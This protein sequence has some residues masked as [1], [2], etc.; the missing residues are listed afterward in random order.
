MPKTV[1]SFLI[2]ACLFPL[3]LAL[4]RLMIAWGPKLGLVDEPDARRIHT[5]PIPRAGGV[6]LFVTMVTGLLLLKWLGEGFTGMLSGPWLLHFLGASTLLAVIGIVD[7]RRGV[8]AWVKLVVQV[9]A[10][11][12]MFLHNPGGAGI[13][14]GFHVPWIID[15]G[16]HV[17]WTVALINAFNLID[18][19]DGL[20]SG[21][22]TI[23]LVILAALAAVGHYASNGF[24]IMVMAVGLMGFLRYNFHPARIFLGDT[25]SM[26]VGFF[27]ASVGTVTVGRHAVVAGLLLPLLVGGVPLLDVGLAVWRRGMRRLADSRPGKATIHIF[28]ADRDHLHHRLLNW[29]LSQRQAVFAIYGLAAVTSMLALLPIL[30]GTNLVTVSV[31]GILVISLVGLRYI[32][33]VEFLE[34]GRGLRAY[35]R[36]PRNCR[37]AMVTYLIH[38]LIALFASAMLASWLVEKGSARAYDWKEAMPDVMIFSVCTLVGL[39]LG[40]AHARRWARAS[41]HDFAECILWMVCGAGISFAFLGMADSDFSFHD[42]IFH[43]S[44]LALGT[45]AVFASRCTGFLLQESV[46]D[47]MHRKR[48]MRSKRSS[49]T[50]IIYGAGDLGELFLCHLRLSQPEVWKD[51]HFVGFIDDSEGLR[52]RRMRGFPILGSL[53]Q[54]PRLVAQN[55]VNCIMVTSSVL[56]EE[57]TSE[58][59]I[60][61]EELEVEV[62]RWQPSL[63]PECLARPLT[64]RAACGVV[65]VPQQV[66]EIPKPV[67]TSDLTPA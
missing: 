17:A 57:K 18:G 47:T 48:R 62:H 24:V 6:G 44:A 12:V 67:D 13:F 8:S 7:D 1:W 63:E 25:G 55:G 2:L 5:T 66:L 50:A 22:G 28:G 29:G 45:V 33:P 21:L 26:M 38:D 3:S 23:A 61:A 60:L 15:L 65:P 19:M 4:T 52:G 54:L 34:S 49:K 51:Y 27:I 53:A 42:V 11:I 32:A 16:I 10:A 30:G 20:C 14:M 43:L 59:M 56:P 36:K 35:V 9:L 31:V 39:V 58:L 46:I 40:R 41:T 37:Q 64:V